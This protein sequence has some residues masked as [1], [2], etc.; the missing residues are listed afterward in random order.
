M[1]P[2]AYLLHSHGKSPFFRTVN[3]L[4]LWSYT[5]AYW[6]V[7]CIHGSYWDHNTGVIYDWLV[8]S[9][10]LKHISM[11]L[12]M[13]IYDKN[14]P[15]FF[16]HRMPRDA[17]AMPRSPIWRCWRSPSK[18][19]FSSA[20]GRRCQRK[21]QPLLAGKKGFFWDKNGRKAKKNDYL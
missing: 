7:Y 16:T 8:V 1:I 20:T 14:P 3:H 6:D 9:T 13:N 11:E 2:F 19:R 4:F 5:W 17:Q 18:K 15:V 12:Y 21:R 10:P